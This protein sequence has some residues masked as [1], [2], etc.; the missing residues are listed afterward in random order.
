MSFKA[1]RNLREYELMLVGL[2]I[3]SLASSNVLWIIEKTSFSI[4]LLSVSSLSL[5]ILGLNLMII[6][7]KNI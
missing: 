2:F 4:A 6:N 5:F 1:L 3:T 7:I